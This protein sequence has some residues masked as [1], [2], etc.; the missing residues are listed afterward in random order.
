MN[1]CR[2]KIDYCHAKMQSSCAIHDINMKK[3]FIISGRLIEISYDAIELINEIVN[4]I[5]LCRYF[6]SFIQNCTR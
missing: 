6:L 5:I 4:I 3:Y 1:N 2:F